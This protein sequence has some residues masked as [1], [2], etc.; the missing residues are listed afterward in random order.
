MTDQPDDQDEERRP[1]VLAA[2]AFKCTG[3]HPFA[4]DPETVAERLDAE[5][6]L[7][8]NADPAALARAARRRRNF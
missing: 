3:T 8:A 4:A 2:R 5:A 1:E 7:I 6:E